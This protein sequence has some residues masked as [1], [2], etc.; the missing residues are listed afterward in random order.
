MQL[1]ILT[2]TFHLHGC[3]SLKEK[4]QALAGARDRFGRLPW[5]A[6]CESGLHD[7][8][9]SAEWSFVVTGQRREDVQRAL[10]EIEQFLATR[11]DTV[12]TGA[13]REWC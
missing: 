5:V 2:V 6:V 4:R 1:A 13:T 7:Q 9:D 8:L 10:D 12:I 3:N 11:T